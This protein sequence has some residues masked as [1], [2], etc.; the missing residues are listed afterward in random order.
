MAD[1]PMRWV[2]I[3]SW[4]EAEISAGAAFCCSLRDDTVS[5]ISSRSDDWRLMVRRAVPTCVRM[6]R[7]PITVAAFFSARSMS[8]LILSMS[9]VYSTATGASSMAGSPLLS[10]RTVRARTSAL[11]CTSGKA[12]GLPTRAWETD[13]ARR[14]D[15]ISDW[16]VAATCWATLSVWRTVNTAMEPSTMSEKASS[17]ASVRWCWATVRRPSK[18]M[19]S[20]SSSPASA[21]S[22][23][24]INGSTGGGS[25]RL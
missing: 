5:A 8:G 3:T 17:T 13:L 22:S 18:G 24:A 12:C 20:N 6:A 14:C 15:C 9:S 7:W 1:L 2:S 10:P 4:P 19:S 11:S 21:A 25:C 23:P 16:P